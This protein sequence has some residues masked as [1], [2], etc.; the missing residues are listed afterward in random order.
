MVAIS[1]VGSHCEVNEVVPG[2]ENTNNQTSSKSPSFTD[3]QD[4]A[5]CEYPTG[6][7]EQTFLESS[8][9]MLC[10]L[11]I[12]AAFAWKKIVCVLCALIAMIYCLNKFH[13]K[14]LATPSGQDVAGDDA[15]MD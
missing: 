4:F 13:N 6:D 8:L 5:T 15:T 14:L 11:C 12:F 2:M 1:L 3:K 7:T 9:C 10:M